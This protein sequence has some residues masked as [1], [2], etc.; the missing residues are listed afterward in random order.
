MT[1]QNSPQEIESC[2]I[3]GQL[4]ALVI[5]ADYSVSKT[6]FITPNECTQQVGFIC[7]AANT[8]IPR[9][10]HLPLSRTIL[11]TTEVVTVR[12]GRCTAEIYG[13]DKRPVAEYELREGDV[14]LLNG[15]A[16]GFRVHE[17]T[18]LLEV[19]QG[20]YTDKPEKERF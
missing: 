18:V 5:R 14:I 15:G 19:K 17:D 13:P 2:V 9:H 10:A 20:P 8:V 6:T 7:Y 1:P 12:R 4:L 11:G 3:D 16:H